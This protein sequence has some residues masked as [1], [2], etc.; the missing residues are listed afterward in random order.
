MTTKNLIILLFI[1][2][3]MAL[4]AYQGGIP[5]VH[6]ADSTTAK[7]YKMSIKDLNASALSIV[8]VASLKTAQTN[9][10]WSILNK[11]SII[12]VFTNKWMGKP[13]KKLMFDLQQEASDSL[14]IFTHTMG[15][16]SKDSLLQN[17]C[18]YIGYQHMNRMVSSISLSN[19]KEES[20]IEYMVYNQLLG[21]SARSMIE[22]YLAIKYGITLNQ[23]IPTNYT[24]GRGDIIWDGEMCKNYKHAIAGIG[25]EAK[26][27][28]NK[29]IGSSIH[30]PNSPIISTTD[31]LQDGMYLLWGNNGAAMSLVNHD[32]ADGLITSRIWTLL[33]TGEWE[34]TPCN[35]QF[36]IGG[37]ENLPYLQVDKMYYLLVDSSGQAT[38]DE[39]T[40]LAY[41][42][43]FN[44]TNN[45]VFSQ[46]AIPNTLSHF[47]VAQRSLTQEEIDNPFQY[48]HALPS[49]TTDGN[50]LIECALWQNQ[51]I[52]IMIYNVVGQMILH[53]S[54]ADANY[55]QVKAFL[56]S[57]GTY[58]ILVRAENGSIS[59]HKVLRK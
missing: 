19:Q 36:R 57:A 39:Q 28:L 16:N 11:D 2:P 17:S 26:T 47:T 41:K 50:I 46:V 15:I 49:P 4:Y 54:L 21:S 42:G 37:E 58:V 23:D 3:S 22:S 48:I 40:T 1:L 6:R 13:N 25:K 32:L 20:L 9:A 7:T 27:T 52:D 51:A 10:Y 43:N 31:S 29:T 59:T 55:Y 30:C 44:S 53:K 12:T 38:F 8:G 33:P 5:F 35:V 34:H 56:P 24:N 18:L 45:L 14:A